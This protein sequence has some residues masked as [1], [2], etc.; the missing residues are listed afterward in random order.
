MATEDAG[1]V[2]VRVIPEALVAEWQRELEKTAAA[3]R[4]NIKATLKPQKGAV[5]VLVKDAQKELDKRKDLPHLRVKLKVALLAVTPLVIEAQKLLDERKALPYLDVRL[6]VQKGEVAAAVG[7]V[8]AGLAAASKKPPRIKI[9]LDLDAH[10]LELIRELR[11]KVTKFQ[12]ADALP[13]INLDV[14]LDE[15][16]IARVAEKAQIAANVIQAKVDQQ[17]ESREK[18][19]LIKFE[20][21]NGKLLAEDLQYFR[22]RQS[23]L[24]DDLVKQ[25]NKQIASASGLNT[26]V[27]EDQRKHLGRLNN[28]LATNLDAGSLEQVK[29]LNKLQLLHERAELA[30]KSSSLTT[31]RRLRN[32]LSQ[33]DATTS[34][35]LR[36]SSLAFGIFTAGVAVSFAAIAGFAL[37]SFADTEQQLRRTAAVLGT[38]SFADAGAAGKSGAE[39]WAAFGNEVDR[40][41]AA[42]QD[43]VN[44]AALGTIFDQTEIASGTRALAQAGL[45]IDEIRSSL[46]GVSQFAQNEEILP[47]EAVQNLVQGA[48]AA[49]ESLSNLSALADKFTF[50][51]N[52]TTASATEVAAA[53]SNRAAPAFK[54]Y[55]E[56]VSETLAILN[57]FAASGIKGKT[58]GEQ[59]GILIR[60][61]NKAAVKTPETTA[62]FKKYGI[63]IGKVNGKQVDFATTLGQLATV[64]DNVRKKQGTSAYARLRKELGLTEKS[65]AGLQQLL[66]QITS[67]TGGD[68][69][70]AIANIQRIEKQ[71]EKSGGATERQ[72]SVLTN[73]L[74]FQTDLLQNQISSLFKTAA[75]PGG[76]AI[77][78]VF[79]ELNGEVKTVNGKI[80]ATGGILTDLTKKFR[81]VGE[82]LSDAIVPSLKK[83]ATGG[84]GVDFFSGLFKMYKGFL[85]GLRDAF[86]EFRKEVFGEGSNKGF[87]SAMG[88]GFATLGRFAASALPKIGHYLG[89][90]VG[91]IKQNTDSVK[92]FAKGWLLLFAASKVLRLLI[93]PVV[94]LAEQLKIV[95]FFQR[96]V[97]GSAVA[98][99]IAGQARVMVGLTAAT[100]AQVVATEALAAAQVAQA[101]TG[102]IAM[103]GALSKGLGGL[104]DTKMFRGLDKLSALGSKAKGLTAV[105]LAVTLG[106]PALIGFAKGASKSTGEVDNLS[107]S[108]GVL[109][110]SFDG[111]A[112]SL[113]TLLH[114]MNAARDT[115]E[116]LGQSF[117]ELAGSVTDFVVSWVALGFGDLEASGEAAGSSIDRMRLAINR[118]GDALIADGI[119]E[120]NFDFLQFGETADELEAKLNGSGGLNSAFSALGHNLNMVGN[121]LNR[122]AWKEIAA[123]QQRF[124]NAASGTL[125]FSKSQIARF[126][127]LTS[128]Q[129]A[130]GLSLGEVANITRGATGS[131]SL[132]QARMANLAAETAILTGK[133]KNNVAWTR[134]A[135]SSS[136][137]YATNLLKLSGGQ[138]GLDKALQ[139]VA[140]GNQR[141]VKGYLQNVK[142]AILETKAARSLELQ[143]ARTSLA[144]ILAA[145]VENARIP[146]VIAARRRLADASKES[147]K[148]NAESVETMKAARQAVKD[149]QAAFNETGG[150]DTFT[151]GAGAAAEA[152]KEVKDA[153]TLA[154]EA[155]QKMTAAQFKIA[156]DSTIAKILKLPDAYKATA[157]EVAVLQAAI[158]ALDAALAKQTAAVAKLDEALQALQS[159]QLLGTKAAADEAFG[160][161]QEVKALQLQKVD[162]QIGGAVGEDP[163]LKAI[164]EQIAAIQL[165]TER[166]SLAASLSLDPL[167][168]KLEDTFTPVKE[169][170][171]DAI[172][173]EF[174]ALNAQKI[175]LDARVS[176]TESIKARLEAIAG[177]AAD[178]FKGVGL[179]VTGGIAAG[180]AAGKGAVVQ[181]ARNT[182]GALVGETNRVLGIASPSRVMAQRGVFAAQGLAQGITSQRAIVLDSVRGIRSGMLAVLDNGVFSFVERGKDV[183]RGLLG[184]METIYRLEVK[185]FVL[186]I[187]SWIRA[188]KGPISYDAQLL[189]PA[190]EAIMSGFHRGLNDGF[191]EVKGWVRNVAGTLGDN[192]P[193]ELMFERSARFLINNA[194]A[195]ATFNADDAF[196]DLMP[197]LLTGLGGF[198]P[199]LSFLHKTLSM[200]DTTEMARKLLGMYPSMNLSSVDRAAGTRT[201]A[202]NISDHTYGIAADLG[203]GGARPTAESRG[204]F[205]K[206]KPL[207]GTIFKQL[208]HDGLGLSSSGGTFSDSQHDDHIHAAWLRGPGFDKHSGKKGVG[209]LNIP[210][211]P[212]D[213]L[214]AI[215]IASQKFRMDPRIIAA[216]MKQ[217]SGFRKDVVSFDGGYGLMQLT[218]AGLVSKA[219]SLGGRLN[220]LANT[221]VGT[222]YLHDLINQLGSL[223]LGLSAYNSGPGGG[224][225]YGRVDVPDYV[226]KVMAHLAELI[227]MSGGR[228]VGTFRRHGGRLNAGQASWVG[229]GG[230]EVFVPDRAGTVI[231]N[232]NIE[233][234]IRMAQGGQIP[235]GRGDYIDNRR[236]EVK[237][238]SPDPIAVA[239]QVD[240]R[241]RAQIVK[242]NR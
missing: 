160:F 64:L 153:A 125:R 62:A 77:T 87:F 70:K 98:S 86:G 7:R 82:Q 71:I 148:A 126:G 128:L 93:I 192:F 199:S 219:D 47:E 3:M 80:V 50:V 91:F 31:L 202:N 171:F 121:A 237:S 204:L 18:L 234:L 240:A 185:P 193:K 155:V 118:L 84:E 72:A 106:I 88:D 16:S 37:K 79:R 100:T 59:A 95:H 2:A 58:A 206:M 230:R 188:N 65:G 147:K 144:R 183:M 17:Y 239:A 104:F 156:A 201:S 196:G 105:T 129:K 36:K 151:G 140:S 207:L 203:T 12:A 117:R 135:S 1:S 30:Q 162:L 94:G 214:E 181:A 43:I 170:S 191:G 39:Q 48:T 222:E 225:R 168:K 97:F 163:A 137:D 134:I 101:T 173:A 40:T 166:A 14:D 138:A 216:V 233:D 218:S 210:G 150:N 209:Q 143:L 20:E 21:H 112:P 172:I 242:V 76:Q 226:R 119:E 89:V 152:V 224:E 132:H 154:T 227:R 159:T 223:K 212:N 96:F 123:D 108:V 28:Q 194:K 11:T 81:R 68:P 236:I 83:F 186:E 9:E 141:A 190:G 63:E 142:L 213:V 34:R 56:E 90:I 127:Q 197:D 231:S 25:T 200:A 38:G 220:P 177:D 176:K 189:R 24:E 75:A 133:I 32:D 115:G 6:R 241:M 122:Q 10:E 69:K 74:A 130:L 157:R 19:K 120:H 174:T 33:F 139:G 102:S 107:A 26:R 145:G 161:D 5:S 211:V 66:S 45:K 23:L 46:L 217:E 169:L 235:A 52:N 175:V 60:E 109:K 114:P 136:T 228:G 27:E 15:K 131:F 164:D 229:E 113:S 8:E 78:K 178:K 198:D 92:L 179:N 29:H 205:A 54:A 184:G 111:L 215:G 165:K 42:L 53:F 221:L 149:L 57:L 182:A 61:V 195:D 4:A 73:T 49:G 232:K 51:A 208:I 167:K 180:V 13:K 85:G 158:P 35:L 146:I 116:K 99:S 44:K 238:N 103:R 41:G 67:G 110:R 124:N 187:A 55:G 22:N